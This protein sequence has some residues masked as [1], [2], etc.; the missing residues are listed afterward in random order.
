MTNLAAMKK[1][2]FA[3]AFTI[4]ITVA[5]CE[6]DFDTVIDQ[7]PASF[8]VTGLR[9]IDSVRYIPGD[10]LL[11]MTITFNDVRD[12]R[13]VYSDIY[14]SAGSK[15]NGNSISLLDN[16]RPENGDQTAGDK[17]Y[18]NK[19]PLSQANPNG[20]YT[21]RYFAQDKN[22][23]TKQ[24]AIQSFSY[25]NGQANLAP[26]ISNDI[27][28]PD[29]LVAN[30]TVTIQVSIKADDPNGL[31]DIE[32]VY[33][34]VFRPDGSSNNTKVDLFDSGNIS[35]HGDQ[36]QGD[37]IYSLKIQ[38]DQTNMKGTYRFEFQARDRGK[39]LSNIINHFVLIQ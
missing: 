16:G 27:I 19:F 37:G 9:A 26:V 2:L 38:V 34:T 23:N 11:L 31:V 25:D 14:S 5:G 30:T 8:Q 17:T 15:L 33:F 20:L 10:S 35:A 3:V 18:S 36:I 4:V 21:I 32:S 22:N 39:K 7:S 12:L 29:T 6:K 1:I 13:S 28:E 24:I